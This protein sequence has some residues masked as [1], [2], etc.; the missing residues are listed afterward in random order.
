MPDSV[1][2]DYNLVQVSGTAVIAN[3]VTNHGSTTSLATY[4][5]W[6]GYEM[7]GIQADP[8]FVDAGS[9]KFGLLSSSPAVD[10]AIGIAGVTDGFAG[11]GPDIGYLERR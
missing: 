11:S 1:A 7:H 9:D 4:R 8:L 5:S 3:G 2:I 10:T 6:T